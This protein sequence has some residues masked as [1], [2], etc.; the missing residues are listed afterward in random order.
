MNHLIVYCS[1]NGS[2][3]HVA[4]V[5]S[6]RLSD[7]GRSAELLDLGRKDKGKILEEMFGNIYQ[8]TCLWIGS[9]VYVDHAVPP[10]EQFIS[11]LPQQN[12]SYA[13]VFVTWGGVCSGV[14]LHE[15]GE[16]LIEKGY[17]LLGA[18]KVVAVHSSMW[19]A[20]QPLGVGHPNEEDD[21]TVLNLVDLVH[22][23][24]SSSTMEHMALRV[25]D[26]Q[27]EERKEEAH[28]KSIATAKQIYPEFSVDM[29]KC[30]QCGECA[31][32]CPAEAIIL[33]PYPQFGNDCFLCLKCVRDCPEI[34]IPL[35][36]SVVEERILNMAAM[37]KETPLTEIFS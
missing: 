8:P 22:E 31:E 30:T 5:I 35:D 23:K 26:Y 32:N 15:M 34:A 18:A 2:T 27:P 25:L 21:E 19:R 36:M 12:K 20:S 14:A 6:R 33:D 16:M 10:V 11:N 3:H 29:D 13:V 4:K 1:P 9:P 28:K 7:L 17:I 37:N 24:L